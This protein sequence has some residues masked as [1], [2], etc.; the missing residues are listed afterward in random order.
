MP[1]IEPWFHRTQPYLQ[2]VEG[3]EEERPGLASHLVQ[4]QVPHTCLHKV[5]LTTVTTFFYVGDNFPHYV[6]STAEAKA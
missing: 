2:Y 3:H 6:V 1:A 4:Y 5:M